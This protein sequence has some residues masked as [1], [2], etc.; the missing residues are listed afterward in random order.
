MPNYK[1]WNNVLYRCQCSNIAEELTELVHRFA[2]V[3]NKNTVIRIIERNKVGEKN[4]SFRGLN[5]FFF[6]MYL[7]RFF[8]WKDIFETNILT[9][10]AY[11]NK[12]PCESPW[13]IFDRMRKLIEKN[14]LETEKGIIVII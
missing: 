2:K 13:H 4:K 11:F 10:Q 5:F 1:V 8:L 7:Y 6:R 9:T 3:I 14:R 12:C